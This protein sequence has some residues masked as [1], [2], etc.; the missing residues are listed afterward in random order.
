MTN[1]RHCL[2]RNPMMFSVTCVDCCL[3]DL[4]ASYRVSKDVAKRTYAGLQH[5]WRLIGDYET[6]GKLD[7]RLGEIGLQVKKEAQA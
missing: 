6:K 5:H 2:E 7:A 1:C 4:R 3:R